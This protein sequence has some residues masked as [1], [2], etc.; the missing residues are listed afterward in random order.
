MEAAS[1]TTWKS[2]VGVEECLLG[3]T[4]R[5]YGRRRSMNG[6]GERE[7]RALSAPERRAP[8]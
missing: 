7:V 6:H 3:S 1:F 8:L 5:K 4:R 2:T